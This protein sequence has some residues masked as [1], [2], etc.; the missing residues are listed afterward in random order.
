M[1][2]HL[3]KDDPDREVILA[4]LCGAVVEDRDYTGVGLFTKLR[5]SRDSPRLSKT[6]RYID[7]APKTHLEHP[8]LKDGAGVLLWF[9]EGRISTLE[10]YCYNEEWP[11]DEDS[12]NVGP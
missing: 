9:E 11:R 8:D 10:C 12:F 6:N 4:Q 5:V 2:K 1:I 7:E 3:V